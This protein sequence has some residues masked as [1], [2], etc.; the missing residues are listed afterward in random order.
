MK[1]A[2]P[3]YLSRVKVDKATRERIERYNSNWGKLYNNLMLG[4]Q[5]PN[6]ILQVIRVEMMREAPRAGL[7]SRMIG[8]YNYNLRQV[9]QEETDRYLEERKA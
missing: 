5:D 8:K 1:R 4:D 7:I 9:M 2:L 6:F 3:S